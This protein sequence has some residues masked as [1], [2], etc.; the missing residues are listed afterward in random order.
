MKIYLYLAILFAYSCQQVNNPNESKNVKEIADPPNE[1]SISIANKSD[2]NVLGKN[3]FWSSQEITNVTLYCYYPEVNFN[4][5]NSIIN[6]EN[7]LHPT[8]ID[9]LTTMLSKES[10]NLIT[11]A[12][13]TETDFE[14]EWVAGCFEP[15]HGLVLK[16]DQN[17]TIGHI[18][19]CLECNQYRLMPE[20]VNYIPMAIFREICNTENV[21]TTRTKISSLYYESI[22]DK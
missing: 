14:E 13:T 18:T 20:R 21:P 16:N 4:I 5:S 10:M 7:Q 19:F 2:V 17:K 12:L 6:K 1:D 8:I 11:E 15:H 9:S 3:Q 22:K